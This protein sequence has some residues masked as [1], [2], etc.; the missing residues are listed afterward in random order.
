MRNPMLVVIS[1]L[2]EKKKLW[3]NSEGPSE[4]K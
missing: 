1:K 4:V 2:D 3:P